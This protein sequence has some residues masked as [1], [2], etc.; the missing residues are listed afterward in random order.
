MEAISIPAHFDGNQILLDQHFELKPN[1]KL[2]VT[3]LPNQDDEHLAWS[4]LSMLMS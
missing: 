4:N 3:V 1:A 2:L